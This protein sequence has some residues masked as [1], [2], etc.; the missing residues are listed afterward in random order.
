MESDQELIELANRGNPDAFEALYHRYRNWVY[1]LAWRFTANQQDAL[2]VLQETFTY[3]LGK[4]PGFELT[5]SMTTFLYPVVRHL[6]IA[7]RRKNRRFT[8][9]EEMLSELAAPV[10]EE[11]GQARSELAAVMKVLPDEQRE[12]LLMRFVDD[13]SL[14]EI[15]DA[16][17]IPLG[18]VKSRLHNALSTLRKDRRTRDYFLE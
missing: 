7:V 9:D 16:L 17:N 11:T 12:V 15:A 1:R 18:T 14:Q 5:A 3:V 4:F 13:M 6:S 10:P 8:S 2:D